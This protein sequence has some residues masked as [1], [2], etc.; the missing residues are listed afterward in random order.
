[1]AHIMGSATWVNMEI[2]SLRCYHFTCNLRIMLPSMN[3]IKILYFSFISTSIHR[4]GIKL[5]P[6]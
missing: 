4:E 3:C 6:I 1:M 5:S 2:G